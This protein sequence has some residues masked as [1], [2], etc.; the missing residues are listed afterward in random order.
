V[1]EA[2]SFTTPWRRVYA[3]FGVSQSQFARIIKRHRSKV[4]RALSDGKGL[5]S[6]R[7]QKVI[8]EAARDLKIDLAPEDVM[9]NV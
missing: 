7:D 5:I 9:P 3:K 6:G 8:L 4:C 1:T 2:G